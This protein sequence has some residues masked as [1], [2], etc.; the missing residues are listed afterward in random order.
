[1]KM[2]RMMK[3]GMAVMLALL[4]AA[5]ASVP[6]DPN[7]AALAAS[8]ER[9][10]ANE[11]AHA[12]ALADQR[13]AAVAACAQSAHVEACML[14][15]V[16]IEA[17]AAKPGQGGTPSAL[18]GYRPPPTRLQQFAQVTA[19]VGGVLGPL[20]SGYVTIETNREAQRTSRAIAELNA[21]RELGI[22]QA[23][24]GLGSDIASAP[25]GVYVGGNYGDSYGDNYTGRDRTDTRTSVGGNLGDTQTIGRDQ[26]GRDRIDNGGVIGDDN[27]TRADSPGPIDDHSDPGDDCAD[28][29]C[30]VTPPV[31]EAP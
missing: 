10:Q 17:V 11:A 22:V 26:I 8:D 21:G 12:E 14:G 19:A 2:I 18:S 7:L 25:P 5:C 15:L 1:M 27:E 13:A 23:L 29:D 31:E 16:A 6:T 24:A 3:A 20:A 4:V 28:S 9:R 30:S